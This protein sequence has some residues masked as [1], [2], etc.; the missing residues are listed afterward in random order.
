MV[1]NWQPFFV[2]YY[3]VSSGT[4]CSDIL[5][6]KDFVPEAYLT[7]V[8][9]MLLAIVVN[10]EEEA[11]IEFPVVGIFRG[12]PVVPNAVNIDCWYAIDYNYHYTV[13]LARIQCT[14]VTE[15]VGIKA[16]LTV[17]DKE[18][19]VLSIGKVVLEERRVSV[20]MSGPDI[21]HQGVSVE[22]LLLEIGCHF[23]A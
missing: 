13:P 12:S 17:L 6:G 18:T 20:E 10:E 16:Y 3:L 15:A 19:A 14:G 11:I 21:E 1:T 22:R 4:E 2:L 9:G 7:T 23:K 8:D 5:G